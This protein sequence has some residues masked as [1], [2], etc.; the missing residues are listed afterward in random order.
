MLPFSLSVVL[1]MTDVTVSRGVLLDSEERTVELL[2]FISPSHTHTHTHSFSQSQ[3]L[4]VTF[5]SVITMASRLNGEVHTIMDTHT[6][7][8]HIDIWL[9]RVWINHN[10]NVV[11]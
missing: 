11:G 1:S 6:H 5:I 9:T 8:H 10:L 3:A 2:I 4:P 7:T